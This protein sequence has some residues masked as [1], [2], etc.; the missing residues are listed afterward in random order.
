MFKSVIYIFFLFLII[1][2][3]KILA[4]KNSI[5]LFTIPMQNLEIKNQSFYLSETKSNFSSLFC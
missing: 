5:R 1:K 3:E 2:N 4:E